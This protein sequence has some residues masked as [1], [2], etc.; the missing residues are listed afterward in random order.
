MRNDPKILQP[1]IKVVG[2]SLRPSTCVQQ[3]AVA[4]CLFT[5]I[6]YQLCPGRLGLA[7]PC[8]RQYFSKYG[9]LADIALMKDKYTGHPRGFGF[10]KFEDLTGETGRSHIRSACCISASSCLLFQPSISVVHGSHMSGVPRSAG[11][12]RYAAL[13]L[14]S[15]YGNPGT[16]SCLP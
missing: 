8:S 2:R 4:Y 9:A 10:I 16:C 7:C 3:F 6:R 15:T 5:N 1:Y 11:T 13:H 12:W 14:C